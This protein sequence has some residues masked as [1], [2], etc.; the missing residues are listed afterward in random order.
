[1]TNSRSFLC[2]FLLTIFFS[3]DACAQEI[4]SLGAGLPTPRV[5]LSVVNVSSKDDVKI[6]AIGG[7][8]EE[9][10]GLS[11]MEEYDPA[12]DTWVTR[13]DLP[14]ERGFFSSCVIAGKIYTVGGWDFDKT[15]A[16]L[17]VY[18][19]GTD[20]WTAKTPMP[21][22]RWGHTTCLV[23]GK[24][25][26]IGGAREWPALFDNTTEVYDPG[27]DTWTTKA[28]IPTSR[29][30]LSACVV[31]G[32]IY[33]I[34]GHRDTYVNY[35]VVEEY[36]P[37]TDTWTTKSSMPT[38]RYGLTTSVVDGKIYAIGGAADY[39]P[40]SCFD[41]VE[42]Y[43]PVT[44]T[45]SA[46]TPMP[47]CQFWLSQNSP[48]VDG[49]IY[50]IGGVN[51]NQELSSK[52]YIYDTMSETGFE[53]NIDNPG[54]FHLYQN[55]PNPFNPSTEICYF[56][57]SSGHVTLTVFNTAGQEIDRLVDGFTIAG[58]HQVEWQPDGLSG[59]MYFYRLMV[60]EYSETKKLIIQ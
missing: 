7:L 24:L 60:D 35:S 32:K 1:M 13:K 58:A 36:D 56:I 17:E 9:E 12:T 4:W 18:D 41:A 46:R 3:S 55:V 23:K 39:P 44:D 53:R 19:P 51:L 52:T 54:G 14:S 38:A 43:D 50:V 33:A 6:Y 49:K 59:G 2:G 26:V 11:H 34:G 15:R 45:W 27:S 21:N 42:V 47:A 5:T 30:A 8:D 57:S 16:A 28:S 37:D 29:W 40:Q 31:N 48:V 25:Y 20:T 10:N 22:P